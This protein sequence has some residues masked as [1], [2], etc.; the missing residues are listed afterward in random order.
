MI[1]IRPPPLRLRR[2]SG[3]ADIRLRLPASARQAT[4]QLEQLREPSRAELQQL[5]PANRHLSSIA[6][7]VHDIELE[8]VVTAQPR[9]DGEKQRR[10]Q[11]AV[12]NFRASRIPE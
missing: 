11:R 4:A 1:T 9:D 8:D 5:Q 3:S 7:L 2:A 12:G 6:F 10:R